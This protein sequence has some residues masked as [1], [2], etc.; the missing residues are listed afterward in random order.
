MIHLNVVLFRKQ[1]SAINCQHW[2]TWSTLS[3][4]PL[5]AEMSFT[6]HLNRMNALLNN[7]GII[8][9]SKMYPRAAKMTQC[10]RISSVSKRCLHQQQ[11]TLRCIITFNAW[12]IQII[13]LNIRRVRWLNA[14]Y[15]LRDSIIVMRESFATTIMNITLHHNF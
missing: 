1:L 13:V 11:W 8:W 12:S 14:Y 6:W 2:Y 5:E 10:L 15:V 4:V 9:N 3:S 7:H